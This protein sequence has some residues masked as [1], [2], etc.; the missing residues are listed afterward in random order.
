MLCSL[1][2]SAVHHIR[3]NTGIHIRCCSFVNP[4]DIRSHHRR[5]IQA[6]PLRTQEPKW[7][8]RSLNGSADQTQR[9]K[10]S[11]SRPIV[12]LAGQRGGPGVQ[13]FCL[14]Y[15]AQKEDARLLAIPLVDQCDL[16]PRCPADF[17]CARAWALPPKITAR[18]R[19]REGESE[20]HIA[21]VLILDLDC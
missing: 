2:V 11:P 7:R 20:A 17:P 8:L 1:H 13:F 10:Q 21:S 18:A 16:N 9:A 12:A 5:C 4:D 19:A 14:L 15:E 6:L 3:S